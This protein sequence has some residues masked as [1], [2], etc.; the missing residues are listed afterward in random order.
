MPLEFEFVR[1]NCPRGEKG[2]VAPDGFCH[3]PPVSWI[4][5]IIDRQARS[6]SESPIMPV[7]AEKVIRDRYN[8]RTF[9]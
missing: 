9:F 7:A 3:P 6:F 4:T 1:I 2:P 8:E 5:C